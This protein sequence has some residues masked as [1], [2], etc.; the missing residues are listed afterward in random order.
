LGVISWAPLSSFED[1]G[2]ETINEAEE[3]EFLTL[4]GMEKFRKET[5]V[6]GTYIVDAPGNISLAQEKMLSEYLENKYGADPTHIKP[7]QISRPEGESGHLILIKSG[8]VPG[9]KG[10]DICGYYSLPGQSSTVTR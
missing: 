4:V 2:T 6:L 7:L 10:K 9:R 1:L 8:F 5:K 3:N